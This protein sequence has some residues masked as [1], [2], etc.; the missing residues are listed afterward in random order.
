[1]CPQS[2]QATSSN[3]GLV[4]SLLSNAPSCVYFQVVIEEL[5]PQQPE[6]VAKAAGQKRKADLAAME[7]KSAKRPAG[8][9]RHS[10]CAETQTLACMCP[11]MFSSRAMA[12][13]VP[14]LRC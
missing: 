2:Q 8:Q 9:V 3:C 11:S 12:D 14:R 13:A 7:H 6:D 5:D 1:M 10:S 4:L